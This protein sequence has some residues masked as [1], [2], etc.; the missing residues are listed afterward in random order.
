[1][2]RRSFLSEA[3]RH[4]R[5]DRATYKVLAKTAVHKT[6]VALRKLNAF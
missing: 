4:Q 6:R 1:V 5:I 3:S 2:L